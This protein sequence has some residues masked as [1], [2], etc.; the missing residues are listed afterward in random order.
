MGEVL[1]SKCYENSEV[2]I[3]SLSN[4]KLEM[5]EGYLLQWLSWYVRLL[6][7]LPLRDLLNLV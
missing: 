1:V 2:D 6:R 7:S 5:L 4:L 3:D